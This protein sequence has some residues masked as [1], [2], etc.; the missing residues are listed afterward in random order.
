ME[1]VM[2]DHEKHPCR[3]E[4]IAKHINKSL[5]EIIKKIVLRIAEKSYLPQAHEMELCSLVNNELLADAFNELAS[6]PMR[7]ELV[8]FPNESFVES[9][10]SLLFSHVIGIRKQSTPSKIKK[11]RDDLKNKLQAVLRELKNV[12]MD[13]DVYELLEMATNTPSISLERK[14]LV[15]QFHDGASKI[16]NFKTLFSPPKLSELITGLVY[17]IKSSPTHAAICKA[18]YSVPSDFGFYKSSNP[19]KVL[20]RR[21]LSLFDKFHGQIPSCAWNIHSIMF[22]QKYDKDSSAKDYRRWKKDLNN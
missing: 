16:P 2:T 3:G 1:Y 22:D 18:E 5:P 20:E 17:G 6:L 19:D 21:F 12:E 8:D 9:V 13:F 11:N 7:E 15:S 10:L 14:Y 4:Y